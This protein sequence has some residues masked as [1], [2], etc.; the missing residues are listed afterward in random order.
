[1]RV[2]EG[3][4]V[5]NQPVRAQVEG[6]TRVP[7]MA[8]HTG[9]H[10]L[11]RALRGHLGEHVHQRGSAVRPDKL[12]FDFS[13]DAPLSEEELRGVEDEVNRVIGEDRA[14]RVF[15]TTQDEARRL[16]AMMLFG[17][18]Y[19]DVVRLVE[20]D[21]YSRELCGGTHVPSTGVVGS[22]RIVSEGSVGQGVRRIEAL[23]GPAASDLLRRHDRAAEAAAKAARVPVAELPE[24]IE[25]LQAR[26]RELEKAARKAGDG[27][28]GAGPDLQAL[29][30][31]AVEQGGFR[32][33]ATEAPPGT[34][35]DALLQLADRLKGSLG[36]SA[37]VLGARDDAGA[38]MIVA[39]VSPE[40]VEHGLN[41]SVAAKAAAAVVG[42]GGGGRPAMARAGGS[43]AAKLP[44]ALAAARDAL[45]AAV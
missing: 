13:H 14:V 3:A 42:G 34:S 25:K 26:V 35:A 10:L 6:A 4:L 9:T 17:E 5:A 40:A 22:F 43:D 24:A 33:L 38:V 27:Q 16:G 8:N 41:A 19:G 31:G 11:H 20:I 21:G 30:Q 23:T 44:E 29:A 7:T 1:V 36:P 15:E 39:T 32:V 2:E 37:V 18:K 28:N 12:R 45:L